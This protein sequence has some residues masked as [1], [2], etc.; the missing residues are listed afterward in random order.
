MTTQHSILAPSASDKW[1]AGKCTGYVSLATMY[2]Q[3]ETEDT[4]R[5]SVVHDMG[6]RKIR[7]ELSLDPDPLPISVEGD[8]TPEGVYVDAGM[9]EGSD[10]YAETVCDTYFNMTDRANGQTPVICIEETIP[11]KSIHDLCFGTPDVVLY[12][13]VLGELVVFD[14]K[15]GHS[16]VGVYENPAIVCYVSG[17]LARFEGVSNETCVTATVIQPFSYHSTGSVRS[18][19]FIYRDIRLSI[20]KIATAAAQSLGPAAQFQTGPHCKNCYPRFACPAALEAG[21]GLYEVATQPIP[22]ELP[23]DQM[24]AQLRIIERAVEQ[25]G[26]LQKSYAAQIEAFCR[27]GKVVPGWGLTPVSGREKW[28]RPYN[29]IVALGEL[30]GVD[31]RARKTLTPNQ[32]RKAGLD[33]GAVKTYSERPSGLALSQIDT[34]RF[35]RAFARKDDGL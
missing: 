11:L 23:P 34:N 21:M 2:P 19:K 18:W 12:S 20:G 31:L 27:A 5:G 33:E 16:Y 17:A 13:R 1:G 28:V 22:Q 24:G 35:K 8:V 10:M 4:I 26:S 15:N 30:F 14:Y 7:N 29:E 9:V 6:A 25:L 3:P 32:A